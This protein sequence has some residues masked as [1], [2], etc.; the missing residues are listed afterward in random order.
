MVLALINWYIV[1]KSIPGIY[2]F[3]FLFLMLEYYFFLKY[4]HFIPASIICIITHIMIIGYE[5][6]VREIG[7][8]ASERSGQPYYPYVTLFVCPS[9]LRISPL[10]KRS[11]YTFA[12]Y[13]LATVVVGCLVAFIWTV[14]PSPLTDRAWLRRDLAATLFLL[15]NY[16]GAI[17]ESINL[18][19]HDGRAGDPEIKGTPANR[20]A[21]HRKRLYNKLM[22]LLPSLLE[23]AEFQRWEP[24]VGGAFP[25]KAYLD[26][27]KRAT[28]INS[29]LALV[30]QTVG[31][32]RPKPP[33][34]SGSEDGS[35]SSESGDESW[36]EAL[37]SLLTKVSPTQHRI[38]SAL[39]L[40]SSSLDSGHALPPYLE[41]PRAYELTRQLETLQRERWQE[42]QQL[43]KQPSSSSLHPD[44]AAQE[45]KNTCRRYF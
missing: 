30:S 42:Q 14:F 32:H 34:D 16:F 12:P 31:A 15:A 45:T 24:S 7:I 8:E 41:L 36:I 40:L 20:L 26:I 4:P 9:P 10:T 44:A 38:V 35:G 25:R 3:L 29:Y 28:R 1:D 2:V 11:I 18:S 19:V 23:H 13:R 21:K 39:S 5:L 22:L 43:K 27:I 17:T 37:G 33:A 6:Q